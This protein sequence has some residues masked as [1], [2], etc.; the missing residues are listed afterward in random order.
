MS[1]WIDIEPGEPTL[2]HLP[3]GVFSSGFTRHLCVAIGSKI[4]DVHRAANVGLY[5]DAV[6]HDVLMAGSLNPLLALGPEQWSAVRQRTMELVSDESER[7]KVEP[8]L[9]NRQ[10]QRFH[11]PWDVADF[12]DFYSS[13]HHAENVGRLF[14]PDADP[15]MPNWLRLP[16]GYHARAGTVVVSGTPVPR[17][18][19]QRLVDGAPRF[20]PTERLDFEV[21]LGYV[22]GNPTAPNEPVS[23]EAAADHVF[24]VVVM[25]DWS[26]R[27]I[28]AFEYQPLG[29]FLGKSFATSVSAWVVP[30]AA[31]DG[32]REPSPEQAPPPV[33]QLRQV[34]DWSFDISLEAWITPNGGE[35]HRVSATNARDLYWTPPQQIAHMT[36]NGAPIR[37]GDLIGT[38]TISGEVGVGSLLELTADGADPITLG[39]TTRSYLLDGDEVVITATVD[40]DGHPEPIGEVCG[41]V[42]G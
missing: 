7:P 9:E 29:P 40:R 5:D 42:V 17:P 14:R 41:R 16:V 39:D 23:T 19:G 1:G 12:V 8:L 21:E 24:G 13:R 32:C 35:P 33:P 11:L 37:A 10:D 31:L 25:N 38:G 30:L 6:P 3:Y 22:L 18:R 36:S 26:A 2:S 27:D 4:F 34:D 15:L 20:E 28:Q